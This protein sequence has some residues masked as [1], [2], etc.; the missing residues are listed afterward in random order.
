MPDDLLRFVSGP[1]AVLA[2]VAVVRGGA[3][4]A[5]DRLVCSHFRL[6]DA[7]RSSCAVFRSI[8]RIHSELL[9]RR[10]IRS[11]RTIDA[12]HR[13]GELSRAEAG[14]QISR[15]LRS[16]LHQATGTPAQYMHL[17]AIVASDLATAGPLFSDLN[18]AQFNA[19]SPVSISDV[20][21]DA[22]E[23]IRTWN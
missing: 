13:A 9:R 14:A 4:S 23:L 10:F 1:T 2:V 19:G 12:R 18:D 16:F 11:I 5:R 3:D 17:E 8:R 21:D 7:V 15:T 22:E 20:G 6:D